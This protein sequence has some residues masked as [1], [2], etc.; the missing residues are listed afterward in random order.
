MYV[1]DLSEVGSIINCINNEIVTSNVRYSIH[2]QISELR[3]A[4]FTIA[5]AAV[6]PDHLV[7]LT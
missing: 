7:G 3:I 2:P 5:A 1:A 4:D 6:N